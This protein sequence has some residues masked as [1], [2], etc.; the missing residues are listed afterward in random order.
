M[1][2]AKG[3]ALARIGIANIRKPE[4]HVK[5]RLESSR[6]I[7]CHSYTYFIYKPNMYRIKNHKLPSPT[8]AF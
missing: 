8:D 3:A 5:A 7:T 6:T 4:V 1:F 2:K